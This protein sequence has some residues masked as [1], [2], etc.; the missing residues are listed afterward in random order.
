MKLFTRL[1][2]FLS[3]KVNTMKDGVVKQKLLSLLAKAKSGLAKSKALNNND[4][5]MAEELQR[6]AEEMQKE[7]ERV[8]LRREITLA[9]GEIKES[10]CWKDVKNFHKENGCDETAIIQL[11]EDNISK[12]SQSSKIK[13]LS[14]I[15]TP[16][17]NKILIC[18]LKDGEVIKT[19]LIGIQKLDN[20]MQKKIGKEGIVIVS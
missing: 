8:G 1:V 2:R 20:N 15:I 10:F 12:I 3:D 9:G 17:P 5:A 16:S 7:V 14:K 13:G 19:K 18:G 11:T 4:K 6:E